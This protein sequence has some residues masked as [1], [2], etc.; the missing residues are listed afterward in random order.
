MKIFEKLR[1][2]RAFQRQHLPFLESLEDYDILCEIGY[3]QE[4][5][6]FTSAKHL[7][8]CEIGTP[9]T[10]RRRL[11]RLVELGVVTKQR[12]T[13]DARMAELRLAPNILKIHTQLARMIDKLD[14]S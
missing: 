3:S 11:E 8:M 14:K 10:L 1:K 7:L 9:A 4:R 13:D 5:E 2:I 12:S 6:G